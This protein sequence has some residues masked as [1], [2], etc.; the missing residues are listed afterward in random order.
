MLHLQPLCFFNNQGK[1]IALKSSIY[2]VV[3]LLRH[4]P[5]CPGGGGGGKSH[6]H[7]YNNINYSIKYKILQCYRGVWKGFPEEKLVLWWGNT[8][9]NL[10][11]PPH[12]ST[13]DGGGAV[14]NA[15]PCRLMDPDEF[16]NA[17]E[18]FQ[19]GW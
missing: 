15:C 8:L 9:L 5:F 1:A 16:Q 19:N 12:A 4:V 14:M 13:W 18:C 17:L 6:L 3:N 7:I 11:C 10:Y 2:S